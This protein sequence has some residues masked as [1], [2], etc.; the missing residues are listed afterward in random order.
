M[1][2]SFP[3]HEHR[4]ID[5]MQRN[6]WLFSSTYKQS[7]AFDRQPTRAP[8]YGFWMALIRLR[9]LFKWAKRE[10]TLE[11]LFKHLK[12]C[13]FVFFFSFCALCL[14]KGF[15]IFILRTRLSLF[16]LSVYVCLN[17]RPCW[18]QHD[19]IPLYC[20]HFLKFN[21]LLN[22]WFKSKTP[23]RYYRYLAPP[24]GIQ[25]RSIGSNRNQI[26]GP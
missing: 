19:L 2:F 9:G 26:V 6:L 8:K 24:V 23:L 18:W 21:C 11:N 5:T 7:N 14:F 13:V 16:F 20:H 15:P 17:M 4:D 12:I 22:V 10:I 25:T 3:K 1:F